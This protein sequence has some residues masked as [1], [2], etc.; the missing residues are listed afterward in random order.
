MTEQLDLALM[1]RPAYP[2]GVPVDVCALFEELALQV[3]EAGHAKYS[4]RA[5]LYRIRWHH[6]IERKDRAFKCNDHW[7]PALA[8]WF[9]K[10]HPEFPDFFEL[11][12]RAEDGYA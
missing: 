7:T 6:Q 4:A 2:D 11:R 1:D 10:K 12:E 3:A 9:L 5:V 8:R